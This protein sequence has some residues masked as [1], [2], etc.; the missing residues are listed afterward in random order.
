[1][2]VIFLTFANNQ[3]HPLPSLSR[4]DD[5]VFGTLIN[6][7]LK[8]NYFIHRDSFTS[9][10]KIN[11]YLGKYGDRLSVFLYSGHADGAGFHL[12][13]DE[14][15]AKGIAYQ[16]EES[17]RKGN[18]K[19]V[20]LNGCSTGGQ[21]K[22]LLEAGIPAVV[23]TSA[24]IE[25]KS[26]TEFSIRFFQALGEKRLTIKEAF[27]EALGAAQTA[28]GRDLQLHTIPRGVE[29]G[30]DVDS[31]G[32]G[33]LW[34]LFCNHP[35]A[36]DINPLPMPS[37][38]T[39]N[40]DFVPNE[41]LTETLF[42]TL[43]K[44]GCKDIRNLKEKEE[45]GE[46][47]EI[48]D[49]QTATVN[50]LPFPVAIHLQKLLCPVEQENEGFD[51]VSLRR[52]EQIGLVYHTTIEF[53]AFVMMAQLWELKIK[54]TA[55]NLPADLLQTI[56]AYFY[57]TPKERAVYDYVPLI[58]QIRQY[59]DTLQN[60]AGIDYFMTELKEL[61]DLAEDGQSFS[62]AL[63]YL[64]NLR[65]QSYHKNIAEADVPILCEEAEDQLCTFFSAFGFLHR[66]ILTSIQNIDVRKYRHQVAAEYNHAIVKLMRAF[67]KPEHNYY[68]LKHFLDNR[69]VVLLKGNLKLVDAKKKQFT[70]D[71]MDYLN[72]S[73]FIID[74]NAFESNTDLSNL[75]F[76]DHSRLSEKK[77]TF[78]S[79]K[80][81][82]SERDRLEVTEDNS[83][84]AVSQ[85]LNA[86][87]T[88]I[89]DEANLTPVL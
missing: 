70:S 14:A 45:E 52:V 76:F 61:K 56:Q 68:L 4:E 11:Q 54:D 8:G 63:G 83:F 16:L 59:F 23:A 27:E 81:P 42:E 55:T 10:E 26:A 50:V 43:F 66:Y 22:Q 87:R 46:Y 7:A 39:G 33:P 77:Y 12:D 38:S 71:K 36:L 65:R 1:M 2:K 25:D 73:P 21:V 44:A 20:V 60:G 67:G 13:S 86:F 3:Q 85:Q 34:G 84:E 29:L 9:L 79:V 62:T 31:S 74:R 32:P 28:T 6:R 41:K 5:G 72:L 47:I 51:K 57:L 19:L 30:I 24:P 69:G 53:L 17:A 88:I 58:R 48:G 15:N 80:Q 82:D 89:L 64:A 35:E 40:P 37:A 78:K 49:K 18:L 75:L